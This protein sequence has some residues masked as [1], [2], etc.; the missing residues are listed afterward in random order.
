MIIYKKFSPPYTVFVHQVTEE[1]GALFATLHH[2]SGGTIHHNDWNETE[3]DLC[4][5]ALCEAQIPENVEAWNKAHNLSDRANIEPE[6]TSSA[7]ANDEPAEDG[8]GHCYSDAD[9]GL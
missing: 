1:T 6:T 4:F 3:Q 9:P 7:Y 5:A 8:C 2:E